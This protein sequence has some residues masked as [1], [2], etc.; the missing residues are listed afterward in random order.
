MASS[1]NSGNVQPRSRAPE[2]KEM[3]SGNSYRKDA[4]PRA[5]TSKNLI[6]TLTRQNDSAAWAQ[7][8]DMT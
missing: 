3:A 4:W 5:G 7:I 2:E 6:D 8:V 1:G